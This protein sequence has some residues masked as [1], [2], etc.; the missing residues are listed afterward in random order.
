MGFN[1]PLTP[2]QLAAAIAATT[3]TVTGQVTTVSSNPNSTPTP[4][5]GT[6]ED[7]V[8]SYTQTQIDALTATDKNTNFLIWNKTTKRTNYCVDGG[9]VIPPEVSTPGAV[10]QVLTATGTND[11]QYG[12]AALP[13][14]A[15]GLV[16]SGTFTGDGT[17]ARTITLPFTPDLV[18][19]S[20]Q[21]RLAIQHVQFGVLL[22]ATTV[23]NGVLTLGTNGFTITNGTTF[24]S[25]GTVYNFTALKGS[26]T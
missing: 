21:S 6:D 8:R 13:T 23:A 1:N 24:N 12:F 9:I 10:G 3:L 15:G 25:S 2:G 4:T 19:L 14:A 22:A 11:G 18:T 26:T 5:S 7:A 16:Y 17:G 20:S